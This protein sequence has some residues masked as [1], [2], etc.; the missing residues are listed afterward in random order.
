M[1]S[2]CI[3]QLRLSRDKPTSSEHALLQGEN[4]VRLA[5]VGSTSSNALAA[6][7]SQCAAILQC[8]M[9]HEDHMEIG[10]KLSVP[11]VIC[12]ISRYLTVFVLTVHCL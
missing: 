8:P 1:R 5:L 9:G 6:R 4:S 3:Y 10:S 11:I 2:K 7:I 12:S